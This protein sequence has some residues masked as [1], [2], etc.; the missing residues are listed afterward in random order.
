MSLDSRWHV[1]VRDATSKNPDKWVTLSEL[2]SYLNEDETERIIRVEEMVFAA[3]E[4]DGSSLEERM[5]ALDDTETGAVPVL[6]ERADAVDQQ[7]FETQGMAD[8]LAA[9]ELRKDGAVEILENKIIVNPQ[10]NE[11][12]VRAYFDIALAAPATKSIRISAITPG[13][14]ANSYTYEVVASAD[15]NDVGI[16]WNTPGLVVRVLKD[17]GDNIT[18]TAY[19]LARL[20]AAEP[21]TADNFIISFDDGTLITE[22]GDGAGVIAATDSGSFANGAGA[23]HVL[24][25]TGTQID[26]A[27]AVAPT[28]DAP[29]T[30]QVAAAATYDTDK[31]TFTA[32]ATG[33]AGNDITV[34]ASCRLSATLGS[35]TTEITLTGE[36]GLYAGSTVPLV[37]V[38]IVQAARESPLVVSNTD[39]VITVSLPADENDDPIITKMSE[40]V[41]EIQN[42][43]LPTNALNGV[44]AGVTT[45][46]GYDPNATCVVSADVLFTAAHNTVEEDDDA[47]LI[48]L[49]YD[50]ADFEDWD[51]VVTE[52][53]ADV[54]STLVTASAGIQNNA[55]PFEAMS[56]TGGVDITAGA[57]GAI[58]YEADKIWISTDESTASVSNWAYAL[59]TDPNV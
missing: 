33:A 25:S 45:G 3:A 37:K 30:A 14:A 31:I 21:E 4:P 48:L 59:L 32:K 18:T 41:A 22:D 35:G 39:G 56:L 13:V 7:L 24:T 54:N 26:N 47:V 57:P 20:A 44:I 53:N 15:P 10:I 40:V 23:D 2:D 46:E 29:A 1:L 49:A 12:P 11:A 28:S 58:R 51:S 43:M 36:D 50:G 52:V 5:D 42:Q 55:Q 38:Q 6:M 34:E 9:I 19:E 17:G 8:K 16:K 27:V